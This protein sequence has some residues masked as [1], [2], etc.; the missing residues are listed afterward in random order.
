MADIHIAWWN[1]ENLFDHQNA[2]RP[3]ALRKRL[4]KEL[5]GWTATVRDK[6]VAQLASVIELT[7]GG[8]GPEHLA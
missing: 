8:N 6:K 5:V 7:F 1:L 3:E 4:K 2:T